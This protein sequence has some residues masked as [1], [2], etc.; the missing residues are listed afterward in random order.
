MDVLGAVD[1][2]FLDRVITFARRGGVDGQ[3]LVDLAR[4]FQGAEHMFEIARA[5]GLEHAEFGLAQGLFGD[6]FG[7]VEQ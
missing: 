1:Q 3:R 2:G 7:F 5:K 4:G 6:A